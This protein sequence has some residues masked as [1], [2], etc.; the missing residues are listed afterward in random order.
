MHNFPDKKFF[1]CTSQNFIFAEL[2][3]IDLKY[4]SLFDQVQILF[5][6]EFDR[7]IVDT[8]GKCEMLG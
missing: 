6:G 8:N 3:Q 5:T 7:V 4:R 1:W 2:P